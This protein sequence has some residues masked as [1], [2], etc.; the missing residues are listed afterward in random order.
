MK[1]L[2]LLAAI[3]AAVLSCGVAYADPPP[4]WADDHYPDINHGQCAGGHGGAFG[5]G[6]CDGIHYPDG[7]Y[8]HQVTGA[9]MD[10]L[11]PHCVIDTG[12]MQPPPAPKGGCGGNA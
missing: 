9:G 3:T 12:D 1:R 4:P 11:K 2:L 5:F 10:N 8:W 7:S 6:W